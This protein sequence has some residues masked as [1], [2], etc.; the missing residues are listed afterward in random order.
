MLRIACVLI[1][2]AALTGCGED[3]PPART[4]TTAEATATATAAATEAPGSDEVR[5]VAQ[6]YLEAHWAGDLKKLCELDEKGSFVCELAR[7]GK[8]KPIKGDP[9]EIAEVRV[10]ED[11][12]FA[13]APG[14]VSLTLLRKGDRWVVDD[15][16]GMPESVVTR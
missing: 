11:I 15:A 6:Q 4:G 13:E 5:D 2:C 14:G 1:C 16:R 7:D 10:Q 9:P 3:D 12:A 8:A